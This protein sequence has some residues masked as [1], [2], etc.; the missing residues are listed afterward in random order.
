MQSLRPWRRVALATVLLASTALT[1]TVLAQPGAVNPPAAAPQ[2]ILPDF[3]NLVAQ[4]KPAVVSITTT[5][6]ASH[7]PRDRACRSH[8]RFPFN[9][10]VPHGG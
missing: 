9:Q 10:M 2:A 4:V 8:C 6:D 1:G 3:S 5:I 7:Q